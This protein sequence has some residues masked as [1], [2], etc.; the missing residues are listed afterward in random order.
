MSVAA[1]SEHT[2]AAVLPAAFAAVMFFT[3]LF[4][5]PFHS[6]VFWVAS[7]SS[8]AMVIMVVPKDRRD[9]WM[10][11]RDQSEGNPFSSGGA[12]RAHG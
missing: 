12:K 11:T 9:H 4:V 7:W 2:S 5:L 8:L 3:S 1:Y 6:P 10:G